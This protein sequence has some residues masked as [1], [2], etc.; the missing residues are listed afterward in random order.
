ME[1]PSYDS[2]ERA[3]HRADMGYAERVRD[4]LRR[5][6]IP[7]S[8]Y[9]I[10]LDTGL[11]AEQVRKAL[12]HMIQRSGGVVALPGHARHGTKTYAL[13]SQQ[14]KKERKA[15]ADAPYAIAGKITVGRGS[16]WY[17]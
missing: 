9:R 3:K 4:C 16:R 10:Q 11:T 17:V 12:G 14:P 15:S 1:L 2:M 13:I 6:G 7:M 8:V 5:S